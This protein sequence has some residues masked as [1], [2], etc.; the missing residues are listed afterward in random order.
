MDPTL[1]TFEAV[2]N[3][4]GNEGGEATFH[5]DGYGFRHSFNEVINW[6]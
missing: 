2:L 6:K 1:P 5:V 4:N 3:K